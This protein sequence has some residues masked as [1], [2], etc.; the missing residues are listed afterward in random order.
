VSLVALG[1]PEVVPA[2]PS[3]KRSLHE[4]LHWEKF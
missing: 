3:L 1:Y 2:G 4:V